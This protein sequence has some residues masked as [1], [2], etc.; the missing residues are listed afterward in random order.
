MGARREPDGQ[1]YT[2]RLVDFVGGVRGESIC[3]MAY[4]CKMRGYFWGRTSENPQKAKFAEF[5]FHAL[6]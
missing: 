4:F 1:G 5:L 3:Q 2:T 6:R